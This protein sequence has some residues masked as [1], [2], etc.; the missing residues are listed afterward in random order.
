MQL[1]LRRAFEQTKMR[2]A[3][4]LEG[5]NAAGRS[6]N[7]SDQKVEPPFSCGGRHMHMAKQGGAEH[8]TMQLPLPHARE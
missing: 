2:K 4:D 6:F 7:Y 3:R 5:L 8:T 1:Q